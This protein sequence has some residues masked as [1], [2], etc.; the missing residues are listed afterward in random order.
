MEIDS[1]VDPAQQCGLVECLRPA[2][3]LRQEERRREQ[4]ALV[5]L[6][7][8]RQFQLPLVACALVFLLNIFLPNGVT[9]SENDQRQEAEQD[10]ANGRHGELTW[11]EIGGKKPDRQSYASRA[12]RQ[13]PRLST[14]RTPHTAVL[15][16]FCRGQAAN[17]CRSRSGSVISFS[18]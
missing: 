18:L 15:D 2:V 6:V 13:A 8:Q 5:R 7:G 9:C 11:G 3:A 10:R 1:R 12:V 4:A 17:V 16:T 14:R